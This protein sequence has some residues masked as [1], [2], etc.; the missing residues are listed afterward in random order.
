MHQW[1]LLSHVTGRWPKDYSSIKWQEVAVVQQIRIPQHS[2]NI[3]MNFRKFFWV[4]DLNTFKF[5]GFYFDIWFVFRLSYPDFLQSPVPNRRDPLM[6]KLMHADMLERRLNLDVPEFYVGSIVAVTMS[7]PNMQNRRNRFLGICIRREREGLHSQFTLRNV[8]NGLGMLRLI[9]CDNHYFRC[10]S[11]VRSLQ[12]DH[13]EDRN[14][15][16]GTPTWRWSYLL[17]GCTAW[18]FNFRF[19]HGANSPS[20][21]KPGARKSVESEVAIATVDSPLGILWL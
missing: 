11:H 5:M 6:Q 1:G 15:Q 20:S 18:V 3:S 9:A 19:Q 4:F 21:W 10:R 2:S 16:I 7:D 13:F 12:S 14:N 8:I 17:G